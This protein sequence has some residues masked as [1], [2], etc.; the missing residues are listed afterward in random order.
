M[1]DRALADARDEAKR[2][3]HAKS[4]FL[5][6]MSH[7]LRTPLNAVIGYAEMIMG[8]LAGP[9]PSVYQG[10]AA[11]ILEGGKLELAIVNDLLDLAKIE[12]GKMELHE[13]V[14][15]ISDLVREGLALF[16]TD[17]MKKTLAVDFAWP[18]SRR[19]YGDRKLIKQVIT[20]LF[21]NAIKYTERGSVQVRC[22]LEQECIQLVVEDSGIGMTADQIKRALQPFGRADDNPH[23]RS[24]AGTGLG[25]PLVNKLV[26]LHRGDLLIASQPGQ[27]TKVTVK[28]P[29]ERTR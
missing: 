5:A 19:V 16:E 17:L 29:P 1:D 13:E 9:L 8:A 20:N 4:D 21:S 10:F 22:L 3:N 28:F 12:A 27:G 2:A 11:N 18:K 14:F 6:N 24:T 23:V 25:L 15:C 26:A 7:E